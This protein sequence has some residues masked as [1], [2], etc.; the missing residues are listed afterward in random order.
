MLFIQIQCKRIEYH[1]NDRGNK[2]KYVV[3]GIVNRK[4]F[5]YVKFISI[6][7]FGFSLRGEIRIYFIC[8]NIYVVLPHLRLRVN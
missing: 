8:Y 6:L 2:I 1:I 7:C 3:G 5:F 4:L